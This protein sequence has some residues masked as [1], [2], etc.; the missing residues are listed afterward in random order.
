MLSRLQRKYIFSTFKCK[1]EFML[2]GLLTEGYQFEP[3]SNTVV[4][5]ILLPPFYIAEFVVPRVSGP[6]CGTST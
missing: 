2:E 6:S 4:G 5:I 1:K 3:Q